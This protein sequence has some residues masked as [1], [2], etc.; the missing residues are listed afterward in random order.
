[1]ADPPSLRG[2]QLHVPGA[3]AQVIPW[4][5]PLAWRKNLDFWMV[6]QALA[7][8]ADLW[9]RAPV[10]AV[11]PADHNLYRISLERQGRGEDILARAVIGADGARSPVRQSLFPALNVRQAEN[12]RLCYGEA[13]INLED[14]YFHAIFP[15]G[16][17]HYFAVHRKDGQ[18]LVETGAAPG[19]MKEQVA[20]V[21]AVLVRDWGFDPAREPEWKD[22]CVASMLMN[23]L[24][25]HAFVPAQG[26][27]LLAGDASGLIMPLSGEGIG[28]ALASGLAAAS[29]VAAALTSGQAAAALYAPM[30]DAILKGLEATASRAKAVNRNAGQ[31]PQYVAEGYRAAWEASLRQEPPEGC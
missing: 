13:P 31:G 21:K 27:V 25:S 11:T 6:Q 28:T 7:V 15:A 17:P 20:A 30:V 2:Y 14:G 5:T 3:P 8:G 16:S 1:L 4:P 10:H 26:N 18:L 24:L 19:Q 9:E 22:G 29:S 23:D 12:L